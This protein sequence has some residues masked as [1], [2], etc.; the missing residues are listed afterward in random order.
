MTTF[1]N[2]KNYFYFAAI[3]LDKTTA[4][5]RQRNKKHWQGSP[6]CVWNSKFKN[7]LD[8]VTKILADYPNKWIFY[9]FFCCLNFDLKRPLN[10][11]LSYFLIT[12]MLNVLVRK[13]KQYKMFPSSGKV[14][15]YISFEFR[16]KLKRS[17]YLP[18]FN[19]V[20]APKEKRGR[21]N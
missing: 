17:I 18:N 5:K 15:Q 8:F 12:C 1:F 20:S 14:N 4:P 11:L 9:G 13:N 6:L 19:A 10:I 21:N 2:Q 7:D 16:S 3:S